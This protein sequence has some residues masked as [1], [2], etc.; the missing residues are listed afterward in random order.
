MWVKCGDL[1]KSPYPTRLQGARSWATVRV[2]ARDSRLV[3]SWR[4]L[5]DGLTFMYSQCLNALITIRAQRWGNSLG[6]RVPAVLA[7]EVGLT[8]GSSL[9]LQVEKGRLVL[10]PKRKR[11]R[12]LKALLAGIEPSNLPSKDIW[13]KPMGKEVW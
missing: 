9:D 7:R 8:D 2:L 3:W 13:G 12:S 5:P 11:S 10:T 6:I 1:R 4:G